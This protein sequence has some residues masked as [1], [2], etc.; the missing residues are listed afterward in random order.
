MQGFPVVKFQNVFGVIDHQLRSLHW[1]QKIVEVVFALP[2]ALF[3]D[4]FP[5]PD[6]LILILLNPAAVPQQ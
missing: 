5:E 6:R 2:E 1:R 4:Q 3:F